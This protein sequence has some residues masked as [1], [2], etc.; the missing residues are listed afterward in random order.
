MN[1]RDHADCLFFNFNLLYNDEVFDGSEYFG[2]WI[3]NE[4]LMRYRPNSIRVTQFDL[5]YI[6]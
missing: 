5:E 1:M 4:F 3:R 2:S 6:S